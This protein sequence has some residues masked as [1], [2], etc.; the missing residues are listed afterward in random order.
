MVKLAAFLSGA[1]LLIL[2]LLGVRMLTPTFGISVIVY[3]A[4]I[5]V[6]LAAMAVGYFI[7]GYIADRAPR[8]ATLALT[9]LAGAVLIAAC[10]PVARPVAEAI[11]SARLGGYWAPVHR[12]A[13]AI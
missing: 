1:T 6:F 9:L 10:T 4:V 7:G 5:A 13:S 3:S 2:E 11:G 8:R 12:M